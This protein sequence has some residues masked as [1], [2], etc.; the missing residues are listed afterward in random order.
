M[1]GVIIV[2]YFAPG[3]WRLKGAIC[4]KK[5]NQNNNLN[6][7]S[8]SAVVCDRYLQCLRLSRNYTR[9]IVDESKGHH[10]EWPFAQHEIWVPLVSLRL[11][12]LSKFSKAAG[13]KGSQN[14]SWGRSDCY[15]IFVSQTNLSMTEITNIWLSAWRGRKQKS[16]WRTHNLRSEVTLRV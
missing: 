12:P 9:E 11:S 8:Q 15:F 6:L 2:Y 16:H 4:L 3:S 1:L 5:I 7:M 10:L 14:K 13:L